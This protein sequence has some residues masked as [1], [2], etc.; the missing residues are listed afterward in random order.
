MIA[1]DFCYAGEWLSVK[2]YM[3]CQFE[4]QGGFQTSSAGS[5]LT[6]T[7]V[8]Q[9]GGRVN[10]LV[11]ATYQENFET[12]ISFCKPDGAEFTSAEYA[13]IM[14][15]LNRPKDNSL[16]IG[17]APYI[18]GTTLATVSNDDIVTT[19]D[20]LIYI[21]CKD[22][23]GY[24]DIGFK[25]VCNV[26]KVEHRG[27]IIGFTIHFVSDSPFGYAP[28][29]TITCSLTA[30]GSYSFSDTSD[31]IGYIYPD[32]MTIT[33]SGAGDLT[34][35]NSAEGRSTTIKN[36]TSGEKLTFDGKVATLTSSLPAHKVLN[37]FN[38]QFFRV[39]NTYDN[40]VNKLTCTVP[41]TISFTYTPRRK[42]VF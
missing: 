18:P 6:F 41:C 35:T 20:E 26:S 27:K 28:A 3:V 5:Q 19:D 32:T 22:S 4:D 39:A 11:V 1:T 7:R 8:R 24:D 13:A 15:W 34:L 38:F 25:G 37:D 30:S 42:V 9:F 29:K 2:G 21:R 33:C 31:E 36:V 17:M 10:P 16:G 14:R 23:Y 40:R 12:D